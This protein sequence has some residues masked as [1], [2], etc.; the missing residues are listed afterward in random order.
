[1]LCYAR[2]GLKAS[3]RARRFV[4]QSSRAPTQS[5]ATSLLYVSRSLGTDASVNGLSDQGDEM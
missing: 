2:C 1:M 3:L 5:R 4:V